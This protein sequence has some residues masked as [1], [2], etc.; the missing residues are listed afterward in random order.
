M[1][2][3]WRLGPVTSDEE[4]KTFLA[5]LLKCLTKFDHTVSVEVFLHQW[6]HH[7]CL[8]WVAGFR[9]PLLEPTS[10]NLRNPSLGPRSLSTPSWGWITSLPVFPLTSPHIQTDRGGGEVNYYIIL[11]LWGATAHSWQLPLVFLEPCRASW[12][13]SHRKTTAAQ[14]IYFHWPGRSLCLRSQTFW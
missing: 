4:F 10:W 1:R 8:I 13:R 11:E 6:H 3:P 12:I 7:D 5:V 9:P 2:L 14:I